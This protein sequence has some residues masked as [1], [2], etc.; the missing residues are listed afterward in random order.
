MTDTVINFP[1]KTSSPQEL[2]QEVSETEPDS[3][4]CIAFYKKDQS[5]CVRHSE[6]QSVT[7]LLGAIELIKANLMGSVD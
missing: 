1:K 2:L 3:I 6:I 7:L 4:A 5:F